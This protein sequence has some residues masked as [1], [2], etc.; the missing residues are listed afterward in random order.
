[1]TATLHVLLNGEHVAT[2]YD[3][4]HLAALEHT[5][6][7]IRKYGA[8]TPL[9][10]MSLPVSA[11]TY[12]GVQ[13]RYFL[14][15]LLPEEH[16]RAALAN[17][18]RVATEDTFGLLR[19]YGLDCAGAIQVVDP[20]AVD[21]REPA[22]RWLAPDELAEAI[23]DLPTAP[24]GSGIGTGI[25]ASL[26]GLQGKLP[27]VVDG[28]RI[29]IGE[30]GYASTHILKPAALREN[31]QQRWPGIVQA[32]TFGQR[33]VERLHRAV[34]RTRGRGAAEVRPLVVGGR[35]VLLVKRFDRSG[36][37]RPQRRLHQEDLA[38]AMGIAEKYQRN[39]YEPPRL[40]DVARVLDQ[41]AAIPL[42]ARM[43]LLRLVIANAVLGNCDLHAR[44]LTVM[45]E[46]GRIRLSPAYDVVPTTAWS[47]LDRELA[48]RIG[49][50]ILIDDV[51]ADH[52]VAEARSWG[53]R[54]RAVTQ[55]LS[56]TLD[57]LEPALAATFSEAVRQGWAHPT[58]RIAYDQAVARTRTFRAGL[59]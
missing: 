16:V 46:P 57:A 22:V 29:G 54:P 11:E 32:E 35:D 33:A 50:E 40:A 56:Q 4:R 43:T 26:G 15:G 49:G 52:L 59:G 36:P 9:L 31:G 30:N 42:E 8:G 41:H 3:A 12:P 44:N 55:A 45:L 21:G 18:A 1:V 23:S 20:D 39:D 5:P 24:L 37:G 28:D 34:A 58:V 6:Q 48:L 19:A 53:M 14:D 10:S 27:V 38:Q 17:R 13:T 2:L 51:V 7:A 25:R 47:E